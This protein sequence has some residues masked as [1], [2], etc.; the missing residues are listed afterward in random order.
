MQLEPAAAKLTA[1]YLQLVAWSLPFL[2]VEQVALACLRAAGDTWSSFGVKLAVNICD[3]FFS[4]VLVMGWGPFPK[5][6]WDGLAIGTA[7]GHCV[8]ALLLLGLLVRG[9]SGLRLAWS[10][11]KP[12]APL[13]KRI[14]RVGI[15]GGCDQLSI[16]G[17]HMTFAAIINRLGTLS[18][19]AHGLG[20]Q[21]ES[22]SYVPGTAFQMVAATSA[23]QALG[24]KDQQAAMHGVMRAWLGAV[25]VMTGAGAIFYL[26]GWWLTQFFN[27]GKSDE[28]TQLATAL[29]KILL[30][31][32]PFHSTLMILSGGLRGAGDTRWPLL[33]TFIGLIGIR[34]P[35]AMFFAWPMITVP[36]LGWQIPGC[37][38]GAIGAWYAMLLDNTVR[39][40]LLTARFWQGSWRH[41]EI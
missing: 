40:C 32:C 24:A 18:A 9:R 20:L 8:A 7:L 5:L 31:A 34:L 6:G 10:D 15:P 27:G 4:A 17:C 41:T 1:R 28:V 38:L 21:I 16:I 11:L 23:G 26:G 13:L 36:G 14:A 25:V 33:V 30:W 35:L 29:L 3:V 37:N 2:M 22:L 12:D 39:A 19:A